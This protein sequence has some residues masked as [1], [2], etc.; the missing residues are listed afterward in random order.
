MFAFI[1]MEKEMLKV[2]SHTLFQK[3]LFRELHGKRDG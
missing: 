2:F 1:R 3:L